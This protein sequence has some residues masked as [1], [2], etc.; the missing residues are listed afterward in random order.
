MRN[1]LIPTH[2]KLDKNITSKNF[3]KNQGGFASL[4][5][6]RGIRETEPVITFKRPKLPALCMD[7]NRQI[8]RS[9]NTK[10]P[11]H[12]SL[13]MGSTSETTASHRNRV[14]AKPRW[15]QLSL[16]PRVTS[17]VL[18]PEGAAE[19]ETIQCSRGVCLG[20]TSHHQLRFECLL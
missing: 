3:P 6:G 13:P 16:A 1:S 8:H 4:S 14:T 15:L 18:S 11:P 20:H 2:R 17:T 19:A 9:H 12:S 7:T 10:E 5:S